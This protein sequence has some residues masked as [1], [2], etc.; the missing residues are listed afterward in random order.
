[1]NI[2]NEK[3]LFTVFVELNKA[4][5]LS[6]KSAQ[7]KIAELSGQSL[8]NLPETVSEPISL[9][10]RKYRNLHQKNKKKGYN[11]II[12]QANDS[13]VTPRKL[14]FTYKATSQ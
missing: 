4:N 10:L 8:E 13:L 9:S 12:Q 14:Y 2:I 11:Y 1:M 3:Q 7:L 6:L 5:N